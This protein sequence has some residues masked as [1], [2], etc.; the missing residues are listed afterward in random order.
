MSKSIKL[1]CLNV[2]LFD[3]NNAKLEKF[4][5]EEKSDI[6]CL[7][8]VTRKVDE[9]S[10]DAF[11]SKKIIDSATSQLSNEFYAPNWS[12]KDFWQENFHGKELFEH[13]FGGVVEF[14]NYVRSKYKIVQAKDIFVQ[15]SFAYITDWDTFAAHPGEEQRNVQIVDVQI[16]KQMLRIL[17]YHGIWSKDKKGTSRTEAASKFL[18][19]LVSEVTYPTVLCGDFNLFPDTKSIQMLKEKFVSLVDKYKITHTRPQYNEL[20]SSKRNVVD[21]MFVTKDIAVDSFTVIDS[22]VSDHFPLLLEFHI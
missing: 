14:G 13:D 21:Y 11:I 15:G 8:E 4:L 22:D 20:S 12:L 17:N 3:D 16:G 9:S 2:S 5:K 6:I 7:Q 18:L 10:H 1:L 19:E